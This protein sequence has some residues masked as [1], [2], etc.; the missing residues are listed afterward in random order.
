MLSIPMPDVSEHPELPIPVT[1]ETHHF[2]PVSLTDWLKLCQEA[3][4]P[5][6]GAELL[7]TMNRKD[8]LLFDTASKDGDDHQERLRAA[9]A[10]MEGKIKPAHMLR[11]DFCAPIGTK[12]RLS[13]GQADFHPDMAVPILDDP[14]AY[15]ILF[16]FP[17]EAV[18]VYQRPWLRAALHEGYPVEYRVFVRDGQVQGISNYYPQRPLPHDQD[19]MDTVTEYTERLI[20]KV[21]T[22]FLW[23]ERPYASSF[24]EEHD[25]GGI[26][27]TADYIVSESGSILLLEG[28]PPNELGAH[29]CCFPDGDT[30]GIAMRAHED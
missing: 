1:D 11:F 10:E 26:H 21:R 3:S 23:N 22:P 12:F 27:F 4:V 5:H 20:R 25:R 19:H 29:P 7:T 9:L 6:V 24:F 8:W 15:D 2:C 18:P 30:N 14:R 13:E 16:E 17:R 28:G